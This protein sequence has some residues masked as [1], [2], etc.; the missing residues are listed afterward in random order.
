[1]LCQA[2]ANTGVAGHPGEHFHPSFYQQRFQEFG[3]D[4]MADLIP[5]VL[6][7]NTTPNGVFGTKMDTGGYI[8]PFV[9]IIKTR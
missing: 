4:N 7:K 3:V 6:E 9:E 1:M 8:E 2:L 5:A